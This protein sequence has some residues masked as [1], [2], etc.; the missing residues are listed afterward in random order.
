MQGPS[1]PT[2]RAT[3]FELGELRNPSMTVDDADEQGRSRSMETRASPVCVLVTSPRPER[4]AFLLKGASPNTLAVCSH[5]EEAREHRS[6]PTSP[7]IQVRAPTRS[8]RCPGS[9]RRTMSIRAE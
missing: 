8:L 6:Y 7:V 3:S 9:L 2:G 4:R 1:V 5:D